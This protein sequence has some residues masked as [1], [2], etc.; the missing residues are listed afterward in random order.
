MGRRRA[1]CG[2]SGINFAHLVREDVNKGE[3]ELKKI[4]SEDCSCDLSVFGQPFWWPLSID[5]RRDIGVWDGETCPSTHQSRYE[6]HVIG[7]L[8][9]NGTSPDAYESS[10]ARRVQDGHSSL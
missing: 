7:F 8:M 10:S 3:K 1:V 2:R 6:S 9:E 4:G 5:G